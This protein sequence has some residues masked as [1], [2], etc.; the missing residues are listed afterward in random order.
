ML[1]W[2]D[3]G[4]SDPN[5]GHLITIIK[6]SGGGKVSLWLD[7]SLDETKFV[8]NVAAD[9]P[10]AIGK[11]VD[12]TGHI[13]LLDQAW[14]EGFWEDCAWMQFVLVACLSDSVLK[15]WLSPVNDT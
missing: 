11:L 13:N 4:E 1:Q 2:C 7:G 6:F 3:S 5:N 14:L 8:G 15:G 12:E 10:G 9:E